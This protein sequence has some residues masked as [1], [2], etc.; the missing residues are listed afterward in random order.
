MYLDEDGYG[1]GKL[2]GYEIRNGS[3]NGNE[4]RDGNELRN[5]NEI[6]GNGKEQRLGWLSPDGQFSPSDWG[7]HTSEALRILEDRGWGRDFYSRSAINARDY[8]AQRG[9][10]L[11]HD[12]GRFRPVA[13]HIVPL[14]KRQREFLYAYFM[15]IGDRERAE[16]YMEI[17]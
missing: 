10:C 6:N 14:T 2:N 7:T 17:E 5:R 15:D 16:K 3:E 9:F 13:T 1:F 12:P 8:L 11:I 4:N